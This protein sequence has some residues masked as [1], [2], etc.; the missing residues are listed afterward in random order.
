MTHYSCRVIGAY[1]KKILLI[2]VGGTICTALTDK[3]TLAI[4]KNAGAR[5]VDNFKKSDSSFCSTE[6]DLSENLM[7]LSEN[8]TVDNWN[9]I[10]DT[11]RR[12]S[13]KKDYDGIII[14]HGTDTLAYTAALF[15]VALAGTGIPVI[16][17]SANARL[18][19][20][21]TN[22]N[23]NFRCGVECICRGIPA[24]VYAVYK[25][26]SDGRMYLHLASRLTQCPN[27]SEDFHSVGAM[28]ITN[29]NSENYKEYFDKIEKTYP[30]NEIKP[31]VDISGDWHLSQ[32][33]LMIT[34][35]V[36]LDYSVYDYTAFGAVLHGA[37]HSG[38][39]CVSAT[40]NQNAV[41]YMIEK[42]SDAG[43]DTYFSPSRKTGE[44]Y[45]TVD[46]I[47][48]YKTENGKRINF[49]YGTTSE[50]AYAKL[51]LGYSIFKSEEERFEFISTECN[52]EIIDK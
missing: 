2:L 29:I 44:I 45:E 49:L 41:G 22:G 11:Y 42:C 24:N 36:G 3:G 34:P 13:A 14:A 48:G 26:I 43:V 30:A 8:M 1:M 12:E 28:D 27:Y 37:Y 6:I 20:P 33:V 9:R 39:A 18:D 32:K 47:A 16:F 31:F 15:S 46:H 10:I 50:L 17:V 19:S 40:D 7:I 38:T 4:D 52:F 5:I 21:R 25:N 35:Y 51:L 23:D